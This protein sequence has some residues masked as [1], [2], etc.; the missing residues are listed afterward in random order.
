MEI[1]MMGY[2]GFSLGRVYC[3]ELLRGG[4]AL[5]GKGPCREPHGVTWVFLQIDSV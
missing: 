4:E 2:I 5:A 3:L 1:T